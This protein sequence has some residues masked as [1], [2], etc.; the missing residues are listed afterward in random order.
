MEVV[1]MPLPDVTPTVGPAPDANG[2][3]FD[4]EAALEIVQLT[5]EERARQGLKPLAIDEGLMD[6]A[7]K[8]AVEV[9]TDWG[10]QGLHDDCPTEC[11]ENIVSHHRPEASAADFVVVW[12]NSEGH[13]NNMLRDGYSSIGAGV[14]RL[15]TRSYAVQLFK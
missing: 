2:G 3:Y 14:Y 13:R 4:H 5:N 6:L 12:M 11:G 15:K 7:R 8:R 10:H 1:V 9:V